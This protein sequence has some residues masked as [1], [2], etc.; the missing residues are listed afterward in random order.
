MEPNAK[1]EVP[2][3]SLPHTKR[4]GSGRMG[5]VHGLSSSRM[6]WAQLSLATASPFLPTQ[7]IGCANTACAIPTKEGKPLRPIGGE[8][9]IRTSRSVTPKDELVVSCLP[10]R[11]W[12]HMHR[13]VQPSASNHPKSYTTLV[14]RDNQQ[15]TQLGEGERATRTARHGPVAVIFR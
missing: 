5:T 4:T 13:G 1:G 15:P 7:T 6:R 14:A 10:W 2:S 3:L 8:D 11:H 12:V 9:P